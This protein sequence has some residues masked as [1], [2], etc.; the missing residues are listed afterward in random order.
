MSGSSLVLA[1]AAVVCLASALTACRASDFSPS[2]LPPCQ[3]DADCA[4]SSACNG[5]ERCTAG[6]CESSDPVVCPLEMECADR[7][8]VAS[9]EFSTQSPW[10]IFVNDVRPGFLGLFGIPTALVGKAEPF[11]LSANVPPEEYRG[12][13]SN[14]WSPNGRY[15]LFDP[16]RHDWSTRL[17][18]MEFG[19]GLPSEGQ[20]VPN[21]PN[22]GAWRVVR[23]SADSMRVILEEIESEEFYE[24]DFLGGGKPRASRFEGA[25]W[26]DL[27]GGGI[28]YQR[29]STQIYWT[30]EFQEVDPVPLGAGEARV[31]PGAQHMAVT[32]EQGEAFLFACG[33]SP[34]RQDLEDATFVEAS[35]DSKFVAVQTRGGLAIL[36]LVDFSEVFFI[37]GVNLWAVWSEDSQH[38]L[39]RRVLAAGGAAWQVIDVSAGVVMAELSIGEGYSARWLGP[40]LVVVESTTEVADS[41]VWPLPGEL[42]PLPGCSGKIIGSKD[43]STV[44]CYQESEN[45]DWRLLAIDVA[46]GG[47]ARELWRNMQLYWWIEGLSPDDRNVLVG[48]MGTAEALFSQLWWV[49]VRPE[50]SAPIQ[51]SPGAWADTWDLWQP[52]QSSPLQ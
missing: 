22:V 31:F 11:D 30:S 39:V 26:A 19:R 38:L 4:D 27:C 43:G 52:R 40:K 29:G 44:F 2:E 18:W 24:L 14:T 50:E 42:I 45:G 34:S 36:A 37:Q 17:Y 10:L 15:M 33:P 20:P 49:P 5:D 35:P 51:L 7:A 12:V 28:V 3:V 6:R 32:N 41:G 1:A 8:A 48:N 46:Q 21:L 25:S 47:S 23:W 13:A 16:M 9:C